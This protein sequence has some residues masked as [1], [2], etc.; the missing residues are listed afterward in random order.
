[1]GE[2]E[3]SYEYDKENRKGQGRGLQRGGREE[4][5][6]K[7]EMRGLAHYSEERRQQAG[8]KNNTIGRG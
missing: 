5:I 6:I 3:D 2:R 7:T 4:N 1:V 8:G